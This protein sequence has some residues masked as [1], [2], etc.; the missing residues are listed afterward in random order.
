MANDYYIIIV[1][2]AFI[3]KFNHTSAAIAQ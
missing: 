1:G 3:T 2:K